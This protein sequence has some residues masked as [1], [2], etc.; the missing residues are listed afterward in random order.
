MKALRVTAHLTQGYSA[1]DA[2]SPAIEGI[3]AFWA[4]REQLGEEEF[5]L[6][7]TGHRALIEA[8]LPLA[9]E[10]HG[11]LWWWRASSPIAAPVEQFER[12]VHRRFDDQYERYIR[13]GVK[14]VETSA[15]P[16]KTYRNRR[17][18]TLTPSVTWHVVGE[19]GGVERLLRRCSFIGHG[20]GH[21]WGE[22]REWEVTEDGDED[23]ARFH[24]PLPE[25]FAREH[26]REG[27]RMRWG[28]RPPGRAP[29][30]Q[31]LCVMPGG[32]P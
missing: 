23:L 4:M 32:T 15:G 13:D 27:M 3:L 21:G 17:L 2:W 28:I 14:R 18:V 1:A 29:E 12:H 16:F 30:H 9:R 8:D 26:G 24:R 6:G 22:V 20:V 19:W 5:A 10:E 11:G 31:A 25:A 7:M